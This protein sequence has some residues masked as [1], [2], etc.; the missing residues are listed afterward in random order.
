[1]FGVGIGEIA[2]IIVVAL[3]VVG[4]DR[5]PGLA[6]QAAG[7][8][9]TLRKMADGARDDLRSELGPDYANLELRD[10][11][12]RQLVRKHIAEAWETDQDDAAPSDAMSAAGRGTAQV[13]LPAGELPPFDAEAT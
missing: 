1:M 2:V 8:V 6:K 10:L 7:F 13:R 11:D 5:L 4:P 3:I 9:K 12:P